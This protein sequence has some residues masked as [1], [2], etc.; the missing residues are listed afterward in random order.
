MAIPESMAAADSGQN[1]AGSIGV[2]AD[3]NR[4]MLPRGTVRQKNAA[5]G[6]KYIKIEKRLL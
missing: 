1:A 5:D 2:K 6:R 3:E 4:K